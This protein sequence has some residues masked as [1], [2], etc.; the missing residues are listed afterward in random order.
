M[1]NEKN[2]WRLLKNN[3]PKDCIFSR[4]ESRTTK[5]V[6]DVHFLWEK[7][8]FWIE[9]KTTKH[10]AVNLSPF[11]ISWNTTYSKNGGHCFILVKR[12]KDNGLFLFEGG[13]ASNLREFG[14]S[15][16]SGIRVSGFRELW[17][18]IHKQIKNPTIKRKEKNKMVGQ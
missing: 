16:T 7:C 2:L 5:G 10:N 9:L 11:Q 6:P 1:S 18:Y 4:I 17:N 13:Q 3:L 14:V 15:G 12:S 8:S